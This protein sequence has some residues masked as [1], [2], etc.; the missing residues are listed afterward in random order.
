M[1]RTRARARDRTGGGARGAGALDVI[2]VG[3]KKFTPKKFLPLNLVLTFF[4]TDASVSAMSEHTLDDT[5]PLLLLSGPERE[6]I[7]EILDRR[8]N[9]VAS[10]QSDVK[11]WT[12][13]T[14]KEYPGSVEL[15]LTREVK[16]LRKLAGKIRPQYKEVEEED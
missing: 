5:Q 1:T 4:R 13:G 9:E 8:S 3:R 16:R 14:V 6:Q 2:S 11:Q 10:F 12:Q 7:A 15:A